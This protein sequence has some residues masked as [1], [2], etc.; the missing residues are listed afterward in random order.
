MH[1]LPDCWL[2]PSSLPI[3]WAWPVT[4]GLVTRRSNEASNRTTHILTPTRSMCA[5]RGGPEERN[6]LPRE[7]FAHYGNPQDARRKPKHRTQ[8]KPVLSQTPIFS[9]FCGPVETE[10]RSA[11]EP[12]SSR[13][14]ERL[15]RGIRAIRLTLSLQVDCVASP[16]SS[17]KPLLCCS[18]ISMFQVPTRGPPTSGGLLPRLDLNSLFCTFFFSLLSHT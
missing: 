4:A 11:T 13:P 12:P 10:S 2:V 9:L 14:S 18:R 15:G 5:E 6:D 1:R 16:Q 3:S 7:K 17:H 8:L